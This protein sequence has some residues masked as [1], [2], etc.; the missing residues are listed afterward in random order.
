[1]RSLKTYSQLFIAILLANFVAGCVEALPPRPNSNF[2]YYPK[3]QPGIA[4]VEA[5][6]SDL[7]LMLKETDVEVIRDKK[8]KP[9]QFANEG[10]LAKLMEEYKGRGGIISV[11]YDPRTFGLEAFTIWRLLIAAF[12]VSDDR[13]EV[14]FNPPLLYRDL[15][16]DKL[17][18]NVVYGEGD[19]YD[20]AINFANRYS[21]LFGPRDLASAQRFADD[22]FVIQEH[23]KKQEQEQLADF[24]QQAANYRAL[25]VKPAVSEDQRKLFVQ[26]NALS[27][28]KDYLGALDF[29][30][31]ALEIDPLSYPEAYFNMALLEA[32]ENRFRS[33]I[34]AMKKYLLL[35]PDADDFRSAQDKIYEWELMLSK[36]R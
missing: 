10:E 33:A 32:Q 29:Y 6:K 36:Q 19:R 30:H 7:A 2:A 28:Q 35:K 4:T 11:S 14:L 13:I 15:L 22:L 18:V 9:Y 16:N 5:A 26:A 27:Q 23:L 3:V 31:K 20:Y 1:M 21:F 25:A 12:P 8:Q 17:V 24:E 34:G